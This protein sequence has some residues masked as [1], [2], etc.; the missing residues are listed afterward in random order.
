MDGIARL[1]GGAAIAAMTACGTVPLPMKVPTNREATVQGTIEDRNIVHMG[2]TYLPLENPSVDWAGAR[3]AA[4]KYC[5]EWKGLAR[6]EPTGPTRHECAQLTTT[7]SCL[8]YRIVGDY[9]CTR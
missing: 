7:G 2:A 4:E 3:L 6:A 8:Q 5:L 9:V 1:V